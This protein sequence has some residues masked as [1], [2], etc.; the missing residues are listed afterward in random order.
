[1]LMNKEE[2]KEFFACLGEIWHNIAFIEFLMRCAI[3]KSDKE[4]D[5]LPKPPYDKWK[6]FP[7][8]PSSFSRDYFSKV[9]K[10]FNARF[11][12][13]YAPSELVALRNG[14]AHGFIFSLGKDKVEEL[15]KLK[16]TDMDEVVVDFHMSLELEK[17]I[18]LRQT[19]HDYLRI[20][21][22]L[23]ED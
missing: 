7:N 4:I 3:A 22:K 12:S 19:I 6:I 11:P 8:A 5:E 18:K 20:V 2:V 16:K 1:M 17:M 23:A 9:V 21:I 10:E 13:Y 15:V 14:L